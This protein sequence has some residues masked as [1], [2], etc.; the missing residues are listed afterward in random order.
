VPPEPVPPETLPKLTWKAR[1]WRTSKRL[2]IIYL[3]LLAALV[4]LEN[5]LVYHPYRHPWPDAKYWSSGHVGAEDAEFTAAD[6]TALHGF[7]F[8]QPKPRAVVLFCHGN[9]GNVTVW[10]DEAQQMR[11]AAKV[12]VLTFDYRGYGRS[13]GSPSEAGVLADA[14]AA[15]AW[16]AKRSGIAERDVVIAG[17]SLGGGVAVD[18]AALDGARGLILQN[19]F[20][21]LPDVA[22]RHF[23]IVPVQWLMRNRFNSLAK[24][25]NYHGPL[26]Q[27]HA[28]NDEI[29]PLPLGE[30]LFA[31]ANPPKQFIKLPGATH[32]EPPP[33]SYYV[34]LAKWIDALPQDTT[35]AR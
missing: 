6:G 33:G 9:A 23:P 4:T 14:R 29:V 10:S 26:L 18:L 12:S 24:I 13:A 19:T 15:R 2:A 21:S 34:E 28:G 22:A 11:A 30:K 20:T 27:S 32:N 17:L 25:A 16:L 7:Y 31:A 5:W 8:A 35:G 1:A 3:M